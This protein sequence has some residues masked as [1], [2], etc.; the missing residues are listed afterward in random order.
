MSRAW[1]VAGLLTALSLVLLLAVVGARL[2]MFS[3]AVSAA[4]VIE[5]ISVASAGTEGND[6]SMDNAVSDDG[7]YVAFSSLASNLVAG[8]TNSAADIFLRDRLAGTT[9]LVSAAVGGAPA[10]QASHN[11]DISA[12]GRIIA[13]DSLASNLVENDTNGTW[14]VFVRDMNTGQTRRVS[15]SGAGVEGDGESTAPAVSASGRF[16]AFTSWATNLV[17]SDTN[18]VGDVFVYDLQTSSI[19]RVSV[20]SAGAEGNGFSRGSAVSADGRY[21]AFVSS[22][23]NLVPGDTNA[24]SD[25]FVRDRWLGTTERVSVSSSGTEGNGASS[26]PAI[27]ADGRYVAFSSEASNLVAGDTNGQSDVFVRDRQTGQTWRVS[28]SSTGAEANAGSY[29]YAISGDG[30][31]ILFA[32]DANNLDINDTNAYRDI[33]VHQRSTGQT[34][35]VSLN[36]SGVAGNSYSDV[37]DFSS[38]GR[39][40]VFRSLASNLVSGDTNGSWDIFLLD[41]QSLE[42]P[43]DTP[44][45]TAT[46]TSSP[47]VTFTPTHTGTPTATATPS[48]TPTATATATPT[49]TSTATPTAT[50]TRL[51]TNTPTPTRTPT[52][53]W[54]YT[55]TPTRT[56]FPTWTPTPTNTPGPLIPTNQWVN[57]Y[58]EVRLIDGRPAPVGSIV[59]AYD[60]Q[61]YRCGTYYVTTAG[62]YGPMPVYADDPSTPQ[63][64]GALPGS[65]IRFVVNGQPA[66]AMGPG[67]PVWTAY[68]DI[69]QIHLRQTRYASRRLSLRDGWNLISFNVL[70]ADTNLRNLLASMS[71]SYKAV[72][73][74]RCGQGALSYYPDLPEGMNTLRTFDFANGYWVRMDGDGAWEL[75]GLEAPADLPLPLCRGYNLVSFLPQTS[76]AVETALASIAGKYRVVMSFDP[77]LGARSYYPDLPPSLN[78][79]RTLEPGRGYWIYMTSA[80]EL[81]YP[82][83]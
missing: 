10:N 51:P 74:M 3:S 28:V 68:G 19:E 72:Q 73:T 69:T 5:R 54:I 25:V 65:R 30:D 45:P 22:A 77:V 71:G 46:A 21:V 47:T 1:R 49:P 52:P 53:T 14:D 24:V 15:V 38:N 56:P 4:A 6:D 55:P 37:P 9:V 61:N 75:S 2:G 32:S 58:G 18:G 12:D 79:L 48:Q 80:G 41:F 44:T 13:F 60:D 20:S 43:E 70:P 23:T 76:M 78:T 36:A 26:S 66:W 63:H 34:R 29:C 62:Q 33:F 8:D 11:P 31:K 59:D 42:A 81:R 67:E 39:W 50:W 83:P 27:S 35:L 7:R 17:V 40:I 64:D 57:F 82:L 16:V